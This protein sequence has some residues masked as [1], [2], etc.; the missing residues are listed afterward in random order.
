MTRLP[1]PGEPAPD[2]ELV[3]QHGE[4]VHLSALRG[5]PAAL[6]FFP[7]AFSRVCTRE[8]A[9]LQGSRDLF[10]A[11]GVRLLGISTDSKYTLR[12]YA[13]AEG[14]S[15][16]LLSD[17][18]PHG[19]AARAFGVFDGEAGSARR[20]TFFLDADGV[21]SSVVSSDPGE[22]RSAAAYAAALALLAGAA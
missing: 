12:A 20:S 16:D 3:N 14:L 17:F 4:T 22:P 8:L 7:S 2:A 10:S 6:V 11:H 19:A 1:V 18:W 13:E 9:D 21:V 5:A 15:F